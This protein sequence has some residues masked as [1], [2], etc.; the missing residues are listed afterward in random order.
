M[1]SDDGGPLSPGDC[2]GDH[3]A[4]RLFREDL[5]NPIVG[6]VPFSLRV[7]ALTLAYFADSGWYRVDAG[8][9][10]NPSKWGR[11]AGCHFAE[12]KCIGPTGEVHASNGPFFCNNFLEEPSVSDEEGDREETEEQVAEIHGCDLDYS[13]KAQCS[14]VEYEEAVPSPYDYFTQDEDLDRASYYGGSDSTL[15]YCPVFEGFANGRCDD[16]KSKDLMQV[17]SSRSSLEVF[18]E[19]RAQRRTNTSALFGACYGSQTQS[20]FYTVLP[21]SNYVG[22]FA[23]CHWS[24]RQET[25]GFGE[26]SCFIS[27]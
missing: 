18:G 3:W 2:L 9:V 27:L 17:R 6:D 16:E 11:N 15:D 21:S 23:L 12:D 13:R 25:N 10:A 8:R 20:K 19:V 22:E 1:G 26:L 5:M 7:S 4:R 24:C 14:L